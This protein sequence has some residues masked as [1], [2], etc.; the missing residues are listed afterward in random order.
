MLTIP[1]AGRAL[2]S[3]IH[4]AARPLCHPEATVIRAEPSDEPGTRYAALVVL[5]ARMECNSASPVKCEM[6]ATSRPLTQNRR[7]G[8]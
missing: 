4:V 6:G 5:A 3:V 7:H 2:F 1:P 8:L